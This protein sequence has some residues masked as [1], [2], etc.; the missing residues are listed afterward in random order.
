MLALSA[1]AN[2]SE[3]F[4]TTLTAKRHVIGST[5]PIAGD[6]QSLTELRERRNEVSNDER[7]S[8]KVNSLIGIDRGL[9]LMVIAVAI[10]IWFFSIPVEFRRTRICSEADTAAYPTKCMT[11]DQFTTGI[12]DYYKNGK[13]G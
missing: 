6:S 4:T 8:D 7:G 11:S 13:G 2:T 3:A 12:A 1:F 10:N 9:Y 5:M